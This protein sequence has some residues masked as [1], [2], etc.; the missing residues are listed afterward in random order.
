MGA[1]E[2]WLKI[3][4]WFSSAQVGDHSWAAVMNAAMKQ[5]VL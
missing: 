5:R 1:K 3:V 2:I 4:D